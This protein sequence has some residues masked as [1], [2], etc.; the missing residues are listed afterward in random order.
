MAPEAPR[1]ARPPKEL[2]AFAKVRLEP[3]E[4]T[5]VDLVLDDRSFAYWD[6]GQPDWDEVSARAGAMFGQAAQ[7]RRSPGWQVDPGHYQLLIGRS[8]QDLAA[9]VDLEILAD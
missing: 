2:K 1:L 6:P 5:T 7:E 3:G 4:S 8:S 9:T